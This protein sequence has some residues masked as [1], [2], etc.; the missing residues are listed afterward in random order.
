MEFVNNLKTSILKKSNWWHVGAI[1]LFVLISIIYFYPALGNQS[2]K[3]HDISQWVGSSREIYD[4]RDTD[5]QIGWTNS[6]FSGMPTNQISMEH[7]GT[8][9]LRFVRNI[10]TFGMPRPISIMMLYLIGF[11]FLALSFKIKPYVAVLGAIA[12]AL[13]AHHIIIIEAG[14]NTKAF[15]IAFVPFVIAGFNVLFR[16]KNWILGIGLSALFMSLELWSNHVQITYYM[17]IPLL[18]LGAVELYRA[19]RGENDFMKFGRSTAG[20]LVAYG[21]AFLINSGNILGT[22]EYG[23]F[24]TRG[25]SELTINPDG[26]SNA[27]DKTEGLDRSYITEYSLGRTETFSFIVPNFKGG[28]SIAI[29]DVEANEDNYE[30]L[31]RG[32]KSFVMS[33][34]QYWGDQRIVSGPVYIGIITAFLALLALVYSEEKTKWAY[35][36]AAIIAVLLSWG[37]NIEWLTNF[38]VDHLPGYNKFRAVTISLA[39]VQFALPVLAVLFLTKLFKK[40]EE[41]KENLLPFFIV[42]GVFGV[43]LLALLASPTSFNTFFSAAEE[44]MIAGITDPAY[45][46][47]YDD[48]E[49]TRISIF[50]DDVLRSFAFLVLAFG[51]VFL[52]IKSTANKY[53]FIGATGILL[54]MD[55]GTA[56]K[57][58]L[59]NEKKGKNYI[60][61][62]DS[63]KQNY[64]YE[65]NAAELAIYNAEVAQDIELDDKINKR[66]AEVKKGF[67]KSMDAAEKNRILDYTKYRELN[68]LTNFRVMDYGNPF[69]STYGSYFFKS[70]G[71]YHG[72][73]LGRYQDLVSFHLGVGNPAVVDMLNIKH[74]IRPEYDKETRKKIVG[75]TYLGNNPTALGNAWF[76]EETESVTSANDEIQALKSAYTAMVTPGSLYMILFNNEVITTEQKVSPYDNLSFV[77]SFVQDS[78][79]IQDTI[80]VQVPFQGLTEQRVSHIPDGQGGLTWYPTEMLDSM[81][82]TMEIVNVI[83]AGKEGFDSKTTAIYDEKFKNVI[84]KQSYSGKGT[85]EMTS[86]HP[87]HLIYKSSTSDTE[88]AV[89][90]EIYHPV[91]WKALIDGKETE[92]GRV[93]YVLR[94][95]EVPAGEHEIEFIYEIPSRGSYSAMAWT[96]S[97][98]MILII[99]LG[100]F[101]AP[102]FREEKTEEEV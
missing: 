61:W 18:A 31:D 4:Y 82:A 67:D 41:L 59:N 37:S 49:L 86:Y 99:G 72:A 35:L 28:E 53:L 88:L 8:S 14:H 65:E 23:E 32:V 29:G 89:F 90:S 75:S 58:Y 95:L 27:E 10:L 11:Y 9:V 92:I 93:N 60:S 74:K 73:K 76:V 42:S 51:T 30:D 54:I 2:V 12:F 64:P 7:E 91:G 80:P 6:M 40:R 33:N 63:W 13:S 25:G 22:A 38:L 85:I 83:S 44:D 62:E 101:M 45:L 39:I 15:A 87:D 84:S 97:I 66:L 46:D 69:N 77:Y 81:M 78:V 70:I 36:A 50:R 20:L 24:S 19:I 71:G 47:A 100:L 96:G 5:G 26:S 21:I 79:T 56:S 1:A 16:W 52:F 55:L 34:N 98:V 3:Q 94:A 102:K 43:V 17:M 57:R 68:R 48:L